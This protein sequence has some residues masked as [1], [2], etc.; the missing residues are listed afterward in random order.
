MVCRKDFIDRMGGLESLENTAADDYAIS[1]AAGRLGAKAVLLP[2]FARIHERGGSLWDLVRHSMKWTKIIRFCAPI[3]YLITPL[4]TPV[5]MALA[6][7]ALAWTL[8]KPIAFFAVMFAVVSLWRG[9]MA[10]IQDRYTAASFFPFW[11]YPCLPLADLAA[12]GCW[13]LGFFSNKI[14]WR[15]KKYRLHHGGYL[16]ALGE[17]A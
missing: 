7:L 4:F 3:L 2:R 5:L 17:A 11:I 6:A 12:A 13:L 8:G 16:E 14:T 10:W 9:L 15:G 1:L